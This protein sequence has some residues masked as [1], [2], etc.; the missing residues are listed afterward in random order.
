MLYHHGET[1]SSLQAGFLWHSVHRGHPQSGLQASVVN[2]VPVGEDAVEM[3]QVTL[4]NQGDE[5]LDLVPIA[6]IPI[7]ARSADNFRDHRHVTSLL[8]RTTCHPYGVLVKPSMSFDERGHQINRVTYAVLGVDGEGNPPGS[9]TPLVEDFIGEGGCLAWP[10]AVVTE[11][12]QKYRK[13]LMLLMVLN[14]W[15]GCIFHRSVWHRVNPS[16]I[17]SC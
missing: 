4:S 17:F 2:F 16:A 15:A 9:L 10:E 3:M 6:A 8:H 7:F 12:R 11:V 13:R 14:R 5:P 1:T